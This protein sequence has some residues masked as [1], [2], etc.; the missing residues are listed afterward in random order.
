MKSEGR[1]LES[2]PVP[3]ENEALA[4]QAFR[5]CWLGGSETGRD[6]GVDIDRRGK[7]GARRRRQRLLWASLRRP[8]WQKSF[9]LLKTLR[10]DSALTNQT[11][12]SAAKTGTKHLQG[13]K[14]CLWKRGVPCGRQ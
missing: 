9:D 11:R 8:H 6:R 13:P 12:R 14:A 1:G 5:D 2:G 4:A 7:R 3:D 10:M